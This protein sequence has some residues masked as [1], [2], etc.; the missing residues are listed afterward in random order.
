MNKPE[1]IFRRLEF[2]DITQVM[3]IEK[4]SFAHPW[5]IESYA[6]ELCHNQLAHFFGI[7]SAEQLIAFAG[8]W[9]IVDEGHVANV[10]VRP[11]LRHRGFGEIIMRQLMAV[12]KAKGAA[13]M[14]LEVRESNLDAQHLYAKVGFS[15]AGQ[16][17]HYYDLPDE[18]A[19]IM[20]A[21]L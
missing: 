14:T 3:E 17:P 6:N 4:A 19:L 20:W 18:A 2:A 8:F 16:R 7:F 12:C 1:L 10:A 15:V 5:S 11:D 9:L 13:K 21:D